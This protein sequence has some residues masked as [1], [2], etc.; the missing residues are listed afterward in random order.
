MGRA[1]RSG[2]G[3]RRVC[4][5]DA[6]VGDAAAEA[7]AAT[8]RAGRRGASPPPAA[9]SL[10]RRS[11]R[12][13]RPLA[14]A[15]AKRGAGRGVKLTRPRPRRAAAARAA[16]GRRGS[17]GRRGAPIGVQGDHPSARQRRTI[18]AEAF[19]RLATWRTTGR[20]GGSPAG[21]AGRRVD[22]S[23][24]LRGPRHDATVRAAEDAGH[25]FVGPSEHSAGRGR[26]PSASRAAAGPDRRCPSRPRRRCGAL[27]DGADARP[28]PRVPSR[29]PSGAPPRG[30]GAASQIPQPRE[31]GLPSEKICAASPQLLRRL[32]ETRRRV[33]RRPFS[34]E[35]SRCPG[36]P[37]ERERP[38]DRRGSEPS[39][40]RSKTE[41]LDR[42][43][44]PRR[45]R[46][47]GPGS[48][49]ARTG[50]RCCSPG[51]TRSNGT[52]RRS[53]GRGRWRAVAEE[54]AGASWRRAGRKARPGPRRRSQGRREGLAAS[55]CDREVL[56]KVADA[57]R[58]PRRPSGKGTQ[59]RQMPSLP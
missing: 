28:P 4:D 1:R 8:V 46:S 9:T 17:S 29:R 14:A 34:P 53:P 22:G 19:A 38:R 3:R 20:A 26:P 31:A 6:A 7:S 47:R 55:P 25:A 57:A 54:G 18:S 37:A 51:S 23:C 35:A 24:V 40:S 58:R 39:R 36:R 50:S 41:T 2:G 49:L 16:R 11:R 12:R 56:V 13:P 32:R 43:Q 59:R 10:G 5:G 15:A 33:R 52:Q 21:P 48:S 42:A 30:R 44:R 27:R 45:P